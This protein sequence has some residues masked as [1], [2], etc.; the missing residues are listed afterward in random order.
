MITFKI[1]TEKLI[2]DLLLE[3]GIRKMYTR[4]KLIEEIASQMVTQGF[5]IIGS[6]AEATKYLDEVLENIIKTKG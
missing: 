3:I 4:K 5:P 6:N 2:L 1:N